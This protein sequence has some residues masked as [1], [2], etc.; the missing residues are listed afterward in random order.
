MSLINDEHGPSDLDTV[1][2]PV[3]PVDGYV[4]CMRRWGPVTFAFI[5]VDGESPVQ[6]WSY[7]DGDPKW[8]RN[9]LA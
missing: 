7:L 6:C 8:V 5:E 3:L 2:V 1:L 4:T 9:Y